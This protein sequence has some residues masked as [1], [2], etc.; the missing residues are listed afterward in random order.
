[1]NADPVTMPEPFKTLENI[2]YSY[3]RD[4]PTKIR[5]HTRHRQQGQQGA[6]NDYRAPTRAQI[7]LKPPTTSDRKQRTHQ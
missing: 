6:P 7:Q 3:E 2:T 4:I 1:M 5:P